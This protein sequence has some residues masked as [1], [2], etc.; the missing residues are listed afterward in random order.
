[1]FQRYVS[2][3]YKARCGDTNCCACVSDIGRE[4]R[5]LFLQAPC[6]GKDGVSVSS[7]RAG[8]VVML[9]QSTGRS[10]GEG[11]VL[12]RN[13]AIIHQSCAGSRAR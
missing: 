12:L 9:L 10:L 8:C 13:V 3:S 4:T 11:S 1:M 2:L 6:E 7:L 5:L